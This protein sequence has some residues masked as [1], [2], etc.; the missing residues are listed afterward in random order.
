MSDVGKEYMDLVLLLRRTTK[1]ESML[2]SLGGSGGG[3]W[4]KADSIRKQFP[5]NFMQK[6]IEIGIVRNDAVHGDLQV[7]NIDS[8]VNQ[9]DEILEILESKQRIEKLKMNLM[10]RIEDLKKHIK[11]ELEEFHFF[12]KNN[13]IILDE[14]LQKWINTVNSLDIKKVKNLNK[15]LK[16]LNQEGTRLKE[17]KN[18]TKQYIWEKRVK[19]LTTVF[20]ISIVFGVLYI[21]FRTLA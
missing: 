19:K 7:K 18:Y 2:E 10:Q 6:I 9:C 5:D 1:I 14:D 12:D 20:G 13:K 15:V 11:F 3:I 4:E 8:V 17:I 16:V 21:L